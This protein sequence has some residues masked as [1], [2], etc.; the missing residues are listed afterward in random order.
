MPPSEVPDEE[1]AAGW[2]FFARLHEGACV[3]FQYPYDA[4][5]RLGDADG[6]KLAELCWSTER[7]PS[8]VLRA[9]IRL[10][11]TDRVAQALAPRPL[12]PYR[13]LRWFRHA[14]GG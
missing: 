13:S 5:V 12:G 11:D 9:I 4:S 8:E 7:P 1:P 6:R 10:A 3:K 2:L 14:G